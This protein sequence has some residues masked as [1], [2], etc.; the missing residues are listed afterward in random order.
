MALTRALLTDDEFSARYYSNGY[1]RII[2]PDDPQDRELVILHLETFLNSPQLRYVEDLYI[3]MKLFWVPQHLQGPHRYHAHPYILAR[4]LNKL[5]EAKVGRN[6]PVLRTLALEDPSHWMP[7][8]M[9]DMTLEEGCLAQYVNM[10]L[11][12]NVDT[13]QWTSPCCN[14]HADFIDVEDCVVGNVE[15]EEVETISVGDDGTPRLTR[16]TWYQHS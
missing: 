4:V 13:L 7:A 10:A 12:A 2:F 9:S 1:H 6:G 5:N 8:N 11:D 3:V 16:E 15:E 14:G